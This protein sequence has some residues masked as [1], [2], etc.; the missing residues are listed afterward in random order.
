MDIDCLRVSISECPCMDIRAWIS[1][2]ISTL[3]W[4]IEDWHPKIMDI[5]FD[6]RGFLEIH[7]WICYGFSD[8]GYV[9]YCSL[10]IGYFRNVS[11]MW[12][13]NYGDFFFLSS[14]WVDGFKPCEVASPFQRR[15][16]STENLLT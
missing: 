7:A 2:R 12:N 3:V 6:I 8:Q 13:Q 15:L 16:S 4:I 10:L 14:F 5:H 9:I 1:M 11:C